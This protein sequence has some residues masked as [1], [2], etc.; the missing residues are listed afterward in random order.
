MILKCARNLFGSWR[1]F[2]DVHN[3]KYE[4]RS[5]ER[6]NSKM[7]EEYD[8]PDNDVFVWEDEVTKVGNLI[9]LEFV[10]K[11]KKIVVLTL[12]E[13]YLMNDEGKTIEHLRY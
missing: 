9:V 8:F 11:G 1:I 12:F 3:L 7:I 10:S 6:F 4:Y 13:V 5:Q 2:D